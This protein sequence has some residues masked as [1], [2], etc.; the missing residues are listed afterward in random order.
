[1]DDDKSPAIPDED[2]PVL[3]VLGDLDDIPIPKPVKR[4]FFKAIGQLIALETQPE[5]LR[6]LFSALGNKSNEF[7]PL[8][9]R[10]KEFLGD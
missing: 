2:S 1:M 3:D 7:I 8:D 10:G 5:Y 6:N 9:D 4:N